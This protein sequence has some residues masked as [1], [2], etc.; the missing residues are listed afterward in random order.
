MFWIWVRWRNSANVGRRFANRFLTSECCVNIR[1]TWSRFL[2]SECCVNIRTTWS[3]FLMS[4]WRVN[5]GTTRSAFQT[6]VCLGNIRTK[7]PAF[8]RIPLWPE[9]SASDVGNWRCQDNTET[10]RQQ[11]KRASQQLQKLNDWIA[12]IT[13][14]SGNGSGYKLANGQVR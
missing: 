2:T 7:L 13:I 9:T 10:S 4:V 5:M 3:R 14:A 12:T 6:S 1:T 11:R 8:N